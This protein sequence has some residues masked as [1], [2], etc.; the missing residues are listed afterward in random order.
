M[1][2]QK[3]LVNGKT[4]TLGYL[5]GG[6]WRTREEAYE[7]AKQGK[8]EGVAPYRTTHGVHIQSLPSHK[9][10]L[11]SLEEYIEV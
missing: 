2:V 1:K 10:K 6:R 9:T 8:I 11:Y 7:L 3:R 5:I 4:H